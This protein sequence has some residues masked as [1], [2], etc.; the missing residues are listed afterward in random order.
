MVEGPARGVAFGIDSE[1]DGT[2]LHLR[3][4]IVSV[5][6]LQRCGEPDKVARLHLR[7][8]ALERYRWQV[9]TFIDDD[10]TV[11]SDQVVNF[12]FAHEVLIMATSR[13]P[14]GLR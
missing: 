9:M 7:Q 3:D 8:Y 13:Q 5:T 11:A 1:A 12:V 4:R 10:V 14:L 6:P 2:E